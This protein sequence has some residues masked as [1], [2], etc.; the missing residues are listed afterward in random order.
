MRSRW[1]R[2]RLLAA[3]LM[4]VF[5]LPGSAINA[6]AQAKVGFGPMGGVS[7]ASFHGM[8]DSTTGSRAGLVLGGFVSV[9][10]SPKSLL[11]PQLFYVQKGAVTFPEGGP[12]Q[13]LQLDFIE[14]P[15]LFRLMLPTAAST[16]VAPNFLL[17]PAVAFQV[18]CKVHVESSTASTVETCAKAGHTYRK[19]DV[20]ANFGFGLDVSRLDFQLRYEVGI[21]D[22]SDTEQVKDVHTNALL[23]TLGFRI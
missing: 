14:L 20:S 3:I 7:F 16:R 23:I 19:T 12:K 4:A 15:V 18:G 2:L 9:P 5:A 1:C 11:E 17:G 21:G 8:G 13:T 22:L 10:L 6:Q